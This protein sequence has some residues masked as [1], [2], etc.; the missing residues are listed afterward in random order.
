M[1]RYHIAQINIGRILGP[2]DGPVMAGFVARLDEI[3]ALA[4]SSPGFV[5]RL[6]T[7]AG[8]ATAI[9]PY[10]DDMILLNMSVWQTAEQL[11]DYVYH[12]SHAAVMRQRK[13]WF[14]RF[15]G[16]YLA[17]WWVRAGHIPTPGEGKERLEHLRAHGPSPY[18]FNFAE[19]YPA[20]DAG[21]AQP[22]A[23]FADQ[24]IAL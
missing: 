19:V 4:D 1:T 15:D 6:Q 14:E 22:L 16:P 17:M 7:E 11:R 10:D 24:C 5:W 20:P 13:Q 21:S 2:I 3:N 9:R 8:N 12:T 23:G 18:A